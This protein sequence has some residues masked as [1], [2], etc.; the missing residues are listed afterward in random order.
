MKTYDKTDIIAIAKELKKVVKKNKR[1]RHITEYNEEA[2]TNIVKQCKKDLAIIGVLKYS[3]VY[4]YTLELIEEGIIPFKIS[5]DYWRKDKRQGKIIIDKINSIIEDTV[6]IDDTETLKTVST[7]DAVNKLFTGKER[8]K[9]ELINKLTLNEVKAKQYIKKNKQLNEKIKRLEDKLRETT[10]QRELQRKKADE[11]QITLYKIL[12][13][14]KKKGFPVENIFNTGKSR[15]AP[16]DHILSSVFSDNPTA[17]YDFDNYL[18]DK[19]TERSKVVVLE[20]KTK[21][22][23]IDD[24][25]TF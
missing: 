10:E 4:D 7:L 23:G 17:A 18:K 14:S 5:S 21:K 13:Y 19:D 16:V 22:S 3:T 6:Q 2:I 15:T 25:G 8:D 12:E 24:Y 11:L 9:R 1:G 20:P